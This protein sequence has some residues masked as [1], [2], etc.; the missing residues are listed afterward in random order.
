VLVPCGGGGTLA[1][2]ALALAE[3]EIV[4]VERSGWDD[5]ARSIE[6]AAVPVADGAPP[7]A[8]DAL[9]TTLVSRSPWSSSAAGAR[10]LA[11]TEEEVERAMAFAARPSAPGGG[12]RRE[13]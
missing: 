2:I 7:T 4:T 8:C 9:Q 12:T 11:V 6:L 1:G 10:G 13:P 3:A 5:M